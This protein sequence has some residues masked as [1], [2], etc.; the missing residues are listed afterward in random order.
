PHLEVGLGCAAIAVA[1]LTARR[2][3]A[4][5][6][7]VLAVSVP[8]LAVPRVATLVLLHAHNAVGF[9]IWLRWT[10]GGPARWPVAAL[11]L[12]GIALIAL[13]ACDRLIPE[14][15][16]LDLD[17]LAAAI[18][19][20]LGPIAALR[21]VL[22]YAFAQALH[23]LAWLVL[24]PRARALPTSLRQDFGR[25]G[26]VAIAIAIAGVPAAAITDG[27]AHARDVYLALVVFHGWLELAIVAHLI[28]GRDRL[29]DACCSPG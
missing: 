8:A 28:A 19:P 6:A 22:I 4:V 15:G 10:R 29:E 1:A 12:G 7:A 14:D 25:A 2:I 21:V 9:A 16:P 18:A 17:A 20:G 23:Y 26:V 27:A 3:P 24:I 11:A 13:G 5:A